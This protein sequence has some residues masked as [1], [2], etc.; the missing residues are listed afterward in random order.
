MISQ[1]LS[2]GLLPFDLQA[3]AKPDLLKNGCVLGR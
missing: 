1:I 2:V 3:L